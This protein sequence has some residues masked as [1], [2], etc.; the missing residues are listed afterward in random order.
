MSPDSYDQSADPN[1]V[2]YYARESQSVETRER[3][4]RI[5]DLALLRRSQCRGAKSGLT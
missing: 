5:R 2:A 1:F 4:A 3:F